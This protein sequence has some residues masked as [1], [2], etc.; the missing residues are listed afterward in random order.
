M[1]FP[2]IGSGFTRIDVNDVK[3][4][5]LDFFRHIS[6]S[7]IFFVHGSKKNDQGLSEADFKLS[8]MKYMAYCIFI[9]HMKKYIDIQFKQVQFILLFKHLFLDKYILIAASKYNYGHS[10]FVVSGEVM[11]MFFM[12]NN[13]K[14]IEFNLDRNFIP[15]L[16]MYISD[17]LKR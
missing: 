1:L 12:G 15:K 5:T 11:N 6:S 9:P 17:N 8:I 16:N 10:M 3:S 4:F 2:L 14:D 13:N 7:D